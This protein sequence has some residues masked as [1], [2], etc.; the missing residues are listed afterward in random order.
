MR[1]IAARLWTK[2]T[3]VGVLQGVGGGFMANVGYRE[4]SLMN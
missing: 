4:C 1:C 3:L 2:M